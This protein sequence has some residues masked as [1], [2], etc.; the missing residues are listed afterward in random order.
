MKYMDT[1]SKKGIE[2]LFVMRGCEPVQAAKH[3]DLF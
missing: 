2:K 1:G 3:G